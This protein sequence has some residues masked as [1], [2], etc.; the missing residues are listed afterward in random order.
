MVLL[1]A[2]GLL[3]RSFSTLIARDLEFDPAGIV[4]AQI[5]LPG[6]RYG[7]DP[8]ERRAY[9]SRLLEALHSGL[10]V[11]RVAI[12]NAAPGGTDGGNGFIEIE[13]NE[14]RS[15]GAN[16]RIV[17]HDYFDVLNVA[18]VVGRGFDSR[19]DIGTPRVAITNRAF[20]ERYG[21][22]RGVL[23][24]RIRATSMEPGQFEW[25]TIVG[26]VEDVAYAGFAAGPRPDMY[27]S[28]R[29]VAT[30]TGSMT[31]VARAEPASPG[32]TARLLVAAREELRAFDASTAADIT[33]LDSSLAGL[34]VE[35][36]LITSVLTGFAVLALAL[37]AIG[38]HG[39]LSF[40]VTQRSQELAVRAALGASR[41]SILG[42]VLGDAIKIALLGTGVGLLAAWWMAGLM[43]SLL[44]EVSSRDPLTY[45]VVAASLLAVAHVAAAVPAWRAASLDPVEVLRRS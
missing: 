42:N 38:L 40:S 5:A 19:D 33:S 23:G 9:W 35:Q 27:V 6:P 25:I 20:A 10:A 44:V 7:G 43:A 41:R 45:A 4:T 29:Q 31:V 22:G 24:M 8:D 36:R 12:I 14:D 18:M 2:G 17:S 34:V 16:Y 26:V 1:V 37:A 11:E 28:Y 39:L 21:E 15:G 13:G 32:T 3:V 30:A